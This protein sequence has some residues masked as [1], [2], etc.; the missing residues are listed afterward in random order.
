V[1]SVTIA[2]ITATFGGVSQSAVL[3]INPAQ[4]GDNVVVTQAQYS[5]SQKQLKVQ[6]TS[7]SSTATLSVYETSSGAFLGTMA[8]DGGGKY[9]LQTTLATAPANVTIKS[10]LGGSASLNVIAK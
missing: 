9:E 4:Q 1:T 8:N 5:I 7:T 2:T 3:T 10:S 6:A